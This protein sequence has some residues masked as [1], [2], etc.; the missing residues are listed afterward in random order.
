LRFVL[1]HSVTMRLVF[2]DGKPQE[3]N[4]AGKVLDKMKNA[5]ALVPVTWGLE[6][7]IVIIRTEAKRSRREK[8][9]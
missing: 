9:A 4:Y 8:F 6:V 3:L 1:D 2:G 5:N 7:A